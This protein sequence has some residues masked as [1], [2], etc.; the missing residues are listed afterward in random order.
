MTS[1][2]VSNDPDASPLPAP[3]DNVL[4]EAWLRRHG[5]TLAAGERARQMRM[6]RGALDRLLYG[7]P[8]RG[9]AA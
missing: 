9:D 4:T 8:A 2:T 7:E 6:A 5:Y 1:A 3:R